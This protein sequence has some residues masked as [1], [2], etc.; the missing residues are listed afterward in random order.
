VDAD[1]NNLQQLTASAGA[2]FN[3]TFSP[4]GRQIAWWKLR[5]GQGD[6][7]VMNADGSG[8]VNVT[9]TPGAFEGFPDWHQGALKQ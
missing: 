5:F 4:D 6:I 8:Q 3:P 1:G 2:D 9:T 7:W